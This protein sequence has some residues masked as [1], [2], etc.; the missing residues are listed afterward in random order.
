MLE[1]TMDVSGMNTL[2]RS[3]F[4]L[5]SPGSFPNQLNTHGANWTINPMITITIPVTM[6]QRPILVLTLLFFQLFGPCHRKLNPFRG[7]SPY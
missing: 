4:M 5:I 2:V 1:I 6:I 3:V 7:L